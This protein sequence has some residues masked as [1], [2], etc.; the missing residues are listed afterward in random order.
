MK[1]K[2][3]LFT[4]PKYLMNCIRCPDIDWFD[5]PDRKLFYIIRYTHYFKTILRVTETQNNVFQ[6]DCQLVSASCF[7]FV[8]LRNFMISHTKLFY[9]ER[10]CSYKSTVWIPVYKDRPNDRQNRVNLASVQ[11]SGFIWETIS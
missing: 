2:Y 8:L 11:K 1:I 10:F 9:S 7:V 4:L 5:H 6:L 3:L